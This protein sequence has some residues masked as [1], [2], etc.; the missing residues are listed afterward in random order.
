MAWD[1]KDR[2]VAVE[3][4][5]KPG[6]FVIAQ[7]EFRRLRGARQAPPKCAIRRFREGGT[8]ATPPRLRAH[9]TMEKVAGL[10]QE[11]PGQEHRRLAARSLVPLT[12]VRCILRLQLGLFPFKIQTDPQERVEKRAKW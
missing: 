12:S 8:V 7:R 4:F 2:I 3:T 6:P 10:I 5:L 9:P 1:V 11:E